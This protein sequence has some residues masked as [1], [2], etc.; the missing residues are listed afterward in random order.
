M[1][2]AKK[3]ISS[4]AVRKF[5]LRDDSDVRGRAGAWMVQRALLWAISFVIS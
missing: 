2:K 3:P 1:N 5:Y 4:Q